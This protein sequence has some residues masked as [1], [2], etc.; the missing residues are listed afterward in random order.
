MSVTESA[1]G[2]TVRYMAAVRVRDD[3]HAKILAE[4]SAQGR[5][6]ANYVDWLL[7]PI[8]FGVPEQGTGNVA[9][10]RVSSDPA[11]GSSPARASRKPAKPKRRGRASSEW[12]GCEEHPEAGAVSVAAGRMA[13]G[14]PGC[15]RGARLAA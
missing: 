15:A 5:S 8:V 9:A 12:V 2:A 1:Q 6:A 10:S 4:A 11:R 3:L 14:E 13:C 7:R